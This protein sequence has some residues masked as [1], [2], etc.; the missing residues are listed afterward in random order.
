MT[1]CPAPSLISNVFNEVALRTV[2]FESANAF[3]S[4]YPVDTWCSSERFGIGCQSILHTGASIFHTM[5][6]VLKMPCICYGSRT[7]VNL[8]T[9]WT[10]EGCGHIPASPETHP[11]MF[12]QV[13]H[14]SDSFSEIVPPPFC[15]SPITLLRFWG[16]L[17]TKHWTPGK[18][19]T[20][21]S[22]YRLFVPRTLTLSMNNINQKNTKH[23]LEGR[24][25][26]NLQ[27]N[28]I[29]ATFEIFP[30][31]YLPP[32]VHNNN[33]QQKILQCTVEQRCVSVHKALDSGVN[34]SF[35]YATETYSFPRQVWDT[36]KP[37]AHQVQ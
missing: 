6:N 19:S 37:G 4:V 21:T 14:L 7:M 27:A 25:L 13:Q 33:V 32:M 22:P 17:I 18:Q 5:C 3:G 2:S 34:S 24:R 8:N 20:S 1:I 23:R 36:G 31:R 10:S 11:T 28:R 30:T 9:I 35:Q 16:C 29:Y 26:G 12:L 15:T